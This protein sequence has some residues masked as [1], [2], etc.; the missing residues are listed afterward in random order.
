VFQTRTPV[1]PYVP[2]VVF[3]LHKKQKALDLWF[4]MPE[5]FRKKRIED[6]QAIKRPGKKVPYELLARNDFIAE[7]LNNRS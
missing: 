7:Y 6:K 4:D 1:S 2:I 3:D 5:D